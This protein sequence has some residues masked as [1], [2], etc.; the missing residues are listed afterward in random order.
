MGCL[1]NY[2][3]DA[4]P[5]VCPSHLATVDMSEHYDSS[6]PPSSPRHG[7]R[8]EDNKLIMPSCWLS[9]R[10]MRSAP[11]PVHCECVACSWTGR[12]FI[13]REVP[14][15]PLAAALRAAR[16]IAPTSAARDHRW[17]CHPTPP[18]PLRF[19][20]SRS[21]KTAFVRYQGHRFTFLTDSLWI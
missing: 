13:I 10:P 16:V 12:A 8:S 3:G 15:K 19:A 18:S 5:C 4:R 9:E 2:T 14:A 1:H 6:K 21:R 7:V 11:C 20:R 17:P